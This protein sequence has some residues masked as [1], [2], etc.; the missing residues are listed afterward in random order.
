MFKE[1]I[2]KNVKTK[3]LKIMTAVCMLSCSVQRIRYL[4]YQ[5][6]MIYPLLQTIQ[7]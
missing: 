4:T 5:V 7:V 6:N 1:I 2:K 3:N